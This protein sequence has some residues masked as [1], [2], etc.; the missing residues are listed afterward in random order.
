MLCVRLR[1]PS[2]AR[3]LP[4][5]RSNSSTNKLASTGIAVQSESMKRFH[6]WLMNMLAGASLLLFVTTIAMW[7]ESEFASDFAYRGDSTSQISVA[8]GAGEIA[9]IFNKVPNGGG[10]STPEVHFHH[11]NHSIS[12][13]RE[14]AHSLGQSRSLW[15]R[16]GFISLYQVKSVSW[17]GQMSLVSIPLWFLVLLSSVLPLARVQEGYLRWRRLRSGFCISC[18]YDIR[19]TPDRCPECG[20]ISPKKEIPSS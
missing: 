4:G 2:H 7:I 18:G 14:A 13:G 5:M 12:F 17:G 19:A 6:R 10:P 3:P 16:L 9:V 11:F 15:N 20:T 8:W 1:S